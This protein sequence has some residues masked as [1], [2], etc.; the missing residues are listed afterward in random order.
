VNDR[1]IMNVFKLNEAINNLKLITTR[2]SSDG[3]NIKLQATK[4]HV[5]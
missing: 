3:N 4:R 5:K 1:N 2:N